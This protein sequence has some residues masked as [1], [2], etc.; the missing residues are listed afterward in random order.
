MCLG[1]GVLGADGLYY[2]YVEM[3]QLMYCVCVGPGVLGADGLY[4]YY[5]DTPQLDRSDA[6]AACHKIGY[7]LVIARS[8]ATIQIMLNYFALQYGGLYQ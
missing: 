6:I 7:R 2:Y 8:S 5:V 3:P 4:Y 1:P